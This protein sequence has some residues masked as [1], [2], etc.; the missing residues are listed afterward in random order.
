M[1]TKQEKKPV[2]K[3]KFIGCKG[4]ELFFF[5]DKGDDLCGRTFNYVEHADYIEKHLKWKSSKRQKV[6]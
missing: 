3:I 6:K 5:V 1:S 2:P 4:D